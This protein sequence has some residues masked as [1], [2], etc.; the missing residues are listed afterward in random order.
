M[1]SLLGKLASAVKNDSPVPFVGSGTSRSLFGSTTRRGKSAELDAFGSVS[2]LFSIVSTFANSASQ[3]EWELYRK[4]PPGSNPSIPRAVVTNHAALSCWDAP[5]EFYTRQELVE[6]GQQY[7]DLTGECFLVVERDPRVTFPTG[8]WTVLPTRMEPVKSSTKFLTGWMYTGPDGEEVPLGRDQVIQLRMPNPNDPYRGLG[9]VQ[10]LLTDIDASRFSAEW[11]RRFFLNNAEPGGIITSPDTLTDREFDRLRMQWN[12][13]HRGVS[14]AHRVAILE[15]GATWT[16][17]NVSPKD[18][19][20]VALRQFSSETIRE[21]FGISK[22]MLGQTEDVNRATAEA[23]EYV[24]NKWKLNP[25]LE[26]WKSALNND[27]LPMFGTAATGLEFDYC[28]DVPADTES[29]NSTRASQATAATALV[30]AGWLPE[31]VLATVGLP[32]MRFV[33]KETVPSAG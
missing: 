27:F 5:N 16:T 1:S 24:F 32:P 23:A 20:F 14:N 25:R 13:D 9:P 30:G 18:M 21:A 15:G 31:D 11:N 17:N 10:S 19:Q 6:S 3:V 22:T 33:G 2:T 26:R 12:Q 4:R 29:D 28:L 7:V 8:L